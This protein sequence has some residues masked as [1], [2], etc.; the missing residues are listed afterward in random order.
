[1][2]PCTKAHFVWAKN[3]G[4]ML[5]DDAGNILGRSWDLPPYRVF[6]KVNRIAGFSRVVQYAGR[7]LVYINYKGQMYELF[8]NTETEKFFIE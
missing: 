5:K 3:N 2:E 8:Y 4:C 6:I 1:M 7:G